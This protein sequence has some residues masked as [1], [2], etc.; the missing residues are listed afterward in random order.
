MKL[1]ILTQPLQSNYGGLLQAYALQ[2]VLN[3]MGH[4]V[5][6]INFS[7]ME[8]Y[9]LSRRIKREFFFHFRNFVRLMKGKKKVERFDK[10]GLRLQ[11]KETDKFI[12][13]YLKISPII[14]GP[15]ELISISKKNNFEGYIVGSD[16]VWRPKYSPNLYHFYLDFCK[17]ADVRKIA[18]AASFGVDEWEYSDKEAKICKAL[19]QKFDFVSV[20]EKSGIRLC[21]DNYGITPKWVLD[22]TMLLDKDDYL[23]LIDAPNNHSLN[24]DNYFFYY[25][26]NPDKKKQQL[27]SNLEV[28]FGLKASTQMPIYME[29]DRKHLK[30]NKE[31]YV[32]PPVERWINAINKAKFVVT[33]SFHGCAFSILFNKNFVVLGNKVRGQGRFESLLGLVNLQDRLCTN[34]DEIETLLKCNINWEEVNGVI[35]SKRFASMELLRDSIL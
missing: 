24:D 7:R 26:L 14:C 19:V 11:R 8:D 23:R 34:E 30:F 29:P 6:I 25:F 2:T 13:K 15:S 10:K 5:T 35:N 9:G 20:R 3:R 33:D 16:Q 31:G 22:P 32:F 18:Y 17:D 27:I 12:D 28:K 4:S 1:A 21:K